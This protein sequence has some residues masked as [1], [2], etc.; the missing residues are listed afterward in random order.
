MKEPLRVSTDVAFYEEHSDSVEL[1]SPGSS[2][3]P[4]PDF[5]ADAAECNESRSISDLLSRKDASH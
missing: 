3:F 4:T 2:V 5:P 1:W